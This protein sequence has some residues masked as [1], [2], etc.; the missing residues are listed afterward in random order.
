MDDRFRRAGIEYRVSNPLAEGVSEPIEPA[1]VLRRRVEEYAESIATAVGYRPGVPMADVVRRLGGRVTYLGL[2]E[3]SDAAG[4]IYV[5]AERDFDIL[6]P[7]YTPPTRD[8]FTIAHELGHYFLHANHPRGFRPI[9]ADRLGG[10][11]LE[12]EANWFAAGFLMPQAE[13]CEVA[14]R[15]ADDTGGLAAHFMVSF[16]AADVRLKALRHG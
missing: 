4:S 15:L 13:F 1:S 10:G 6:L 7:A 14:D 11:R 3:V 12:W 16:A 5:H 8:Q 2:D 9:I